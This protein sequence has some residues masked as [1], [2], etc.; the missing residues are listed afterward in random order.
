MATS[1]A[2]CKNYKKLVVT[3]QDLFVSSL[4][5]VI[6]RASELKRYIAILVAAQAHSCPNDWC[7]KELAA[8]RADLRA[9]K[10]MAPAVIDWT[11]IDVC[12]EALGVDERKD[13]SP[14]QVAWEPCSDTL[15]FFYSTDATVHGDTV[16]GSRRPQAVLSREPTTLR[17]WGIPTTLATQIGSVVINAVNVKLYA[18]PV[19]ENVHLI[20]TV[21]NCCLTTRYGSL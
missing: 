3:R 10:P 6:T 1:N 15:E 7:A 4:V 18:L 2:V 21:N 20:A 17:V 13:M 11:D 9:S 14:L 5:K 19:I 16:T 12:A 8:L